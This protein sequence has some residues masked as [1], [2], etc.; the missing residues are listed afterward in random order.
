MADIDYSKIHVAY[1]SMEI[2]I[3]NDIPTYS[4]GLGVL[5]GDTLRS[6]AD[7]EL[8][9]IGITLI[10]RKGYFKQKID[11]QGNQYEEDVIW[12]P[13]DHLERLPVKITLKIEGRN[14]NLIAWLHKQKGE[15]GQINPIILLDTD[16]PENSD[17][18]RHITDYL[19]GKDIYYRLCQEIVLGIGGVKVLEA[20]GCNPKKYHMNEGHSAFLTLE[21]YDMFKKDGGDIIEKVRKKCVFTTH[22]PVPAGHDQFER[23]MARNVLRD[24][25]PSEIENELYFEG[26]LN[27]T[28]IGLRFSKFING[29]AKFH[30]EVSR[31]MFPGYHIESITNGVH[32]AFW[33]SRSFHELY[34]KHLP[35]W[36]SDPFSIRGVLSIKKEEIWD[37]HMEAKKEL[38]NFVNKKYNLLMDPEVFTIGFARRAAVYKR[39]D[40]L[41]SDIERLT[42][43]AGN[44]K[45]IQIIYSG[46][47]HPQD[48][49]GKN[50]I[51]T[52][53]AKLN[54]I[55]G[56]VK[57]CYIQDYD[58]D[59]ARL[60]VSGV[61]VW[62]NTPL[63][64]KEASGTSGMKAAHNGVPQFSILDGW[65][66]EG[67]IENSTGWSIGPHPHKLMEEHQGEETES[68][69]DRVE[70]IENMYD[71][72]E[73]VIIPKFYNER[74]RWIEIMRHTIALNASFFNTHRMLQQYVLEAY[75]R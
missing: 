38:I 9:V 49:E 62:M 63:R 65:W 39:G 24:Y 8:D 41:L 22:T 72:L 75:F 50:V 17:F 32:S 27:M 54:S 1:F 29:V 34:D 40:M 67:H 6:A 57:V 37:A 74:D 31:S 10:Y 44:C 3:D 4:G 45:G 47:A 30:G 43:L 2:A 68:M 20:L 56:K 33:T 14:V 51:R 36:K 18:D 46:K 64:P 52:I 5:A 42:D 35:G 66:L 53:I 55:K 21:L 60:M 11:S 13:E 16:L 23:D 25:L 70:D 73:Y 48:N 19:Y 26:R 58:L 71:K 7:L 15:S 69:Y 12:K 28:H 61:D 59:I